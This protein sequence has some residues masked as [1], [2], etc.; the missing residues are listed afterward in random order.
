MTRACNQRSRYQ[1]LFHSNANMLRYN[2][3]RG[4]VPLST[5]V[6]DAGVHWAELVNH[7]LRL[8]RFHLDTSTMY[9]TPGKLVKAQ[10]R[11][12]TSQTPNCDRV[13]YHTSKHSRQLCGLHHLPRLHNSSYQRLQL[14]RPLG[15]R[16]RPPCSPPCEGR[17]RPVDQIN[18][19]RPLTTYQYMKH[20]S[21][22]PQGTTRAPRA[23]KA[24]AAWTLHSSLPRQFTGTPVRSVWMC[25]CAT[26]RR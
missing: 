15:A 5:C 18:R 9:L 24:C 10:V 2:R 3:K 23:G 25:I 4:H 7:R 21:L 13:A 12:F 22:V 6:Q 16:C 1:I 17:T 20:D 14:P 26:R 8:Q 11:V 19:G